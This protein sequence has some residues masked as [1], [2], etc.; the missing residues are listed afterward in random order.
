[1]SPTESQNHARAHGWCNSSNRPKIVT[2]STIAPNAI[3]LDN[4]CGNGVITQALTDIK[5]PEEATIY[6]TDLVPPMVAATA[7]LA[8]SR[9]WADSVKA[10]TMPAES[11]TFE[12]DF[13][14]DS[15]NNF[16]IFLVKDPE[17][18]AGHIFRT[19]KPGEWLL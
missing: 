2:L 4:G 19:L 11:L 13:F 18:A 6:A 5:K 17:K 9:G 12:N 8:A 1:M 14:I 15:F 3:I 10:E 16:L 7:A